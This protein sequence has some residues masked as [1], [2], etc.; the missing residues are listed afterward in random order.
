MGSSKIFLIVLGAAFLI[1]AALFLGAYSRPVFSAEALALFDADFLE[2]AAGYQRAS[3]R[4]SLMRTLI[5]WAG[6]GALVFFGWN[7]FSRFRPPCYRRCLHRPYLYRAAC[8][9]CPWI[10]IAFCAGTPLWAID[11]DLCFLAGG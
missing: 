4:I 5:N 3:L 8:L 2:R 6:L 1:I 11:A 7:Y 10:T 9:P